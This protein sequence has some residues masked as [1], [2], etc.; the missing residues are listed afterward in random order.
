MQKMDLALLNIDVGQL[1]SDISFDISFEQFQGR[2]DQA[3]KSISEK[4]RR[5][6]LRC[7]NYR[8]SHP[9]KVLVWNIRAR[10]RRLEYYYSHLA[11]EK[12]RFRAYYLSHREE[13]IASAKAYAEDHREERRSYLHDYY[14][15]HKEAYSTEAFKEKKREYCKKYYLANQERLRER[16]KQYY[17]Q[18]KAEK[19]VSV[20]SAS[21]KPVYEQT[22]DVGREEVAEEA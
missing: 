18:K 12:E 19:S 20:N 13:M 22:C 17:Y 4:R 15:S 16:R 9:E 8:L 6:Y 14:L 11:E 2:K 1:L 3:E 5:E 21:I 10:E 7:K